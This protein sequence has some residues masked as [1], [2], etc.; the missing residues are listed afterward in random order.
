MITNVFKI[1]FFWILF[2]MKTNSRRNNWNTS[3]GM[4]SLC[5]S[6]F[7]MGLSLFPNIHS[8]NFLKCIFEK[9]TKQTNKKDFFVKRVFLAILTSEIIASFLAPSSLLHFPRLNVYCL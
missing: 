8:D 5:A 2:N 9:K 1:N 4:K 3:H 6:H 7:Q